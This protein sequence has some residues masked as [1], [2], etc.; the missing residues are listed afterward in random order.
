MQPN[1]RRLAQGKVLEPLILLA[2]EDVS[3]LNRQATQ[4]RRFAAKLSEADH[5]KD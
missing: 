5:R 1:A 3:D 2:I 4:S